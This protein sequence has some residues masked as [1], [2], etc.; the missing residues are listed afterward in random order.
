[1]QY[2]LRTTSY[3]SEQTLHSTK[4]WLLRVLK[5]GELP[6]GQ[7]LGYQGP[8]IV[9]HTQLFARYDT[10]LLVIC[11]SPVDVWRRRHDSWGLI[12]DL[13]PDS[14]WGCEEQVDFFTAVVQVAVEFNLREDP[15]VAAA[16]DHWFFN[17]V[18][19]RAQE[20]HGA[21]AIAETS[22]G[23]KS[24]SRIAINT[25]TGECFAWMNE[26]WVAP[27]GQT[28]EPWRLPSEVQVI[29]LGEEK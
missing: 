8:P 1:M 2:T 19:A 26:K 15:E 18:A 6:E 3:G 28:F 29:T 12:I 24:L 17:Y 5:V 10:K 23:P 22:E 11:R 25:R 20:V 21:L 13:G 9:R 27:D 7:G 14:F 4:T 16:I